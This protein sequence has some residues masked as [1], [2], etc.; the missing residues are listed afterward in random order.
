LVVVAQTTT[1]ASGNYTLFVAPGSYTIRASK[2]NNYSTDSKPATVTAGHTASVAAMTI[3]H[4]ASLT[5]VITD[6]DDA[7]VNGASVEIAGTAGTVTKT[8]DATGT[9]TA[10]GLA[11]GSYT[12]TATVTVSGV[13]RQTGSANVTLL[14]TDQKTLNIKMVTLATIAGTVHLASGSP[15][16]GGTVTISG[17]SS[18]TGF[19]RS[20]SIGSGGT[21]LVQDVPA[22]TN[23]TASAVTTGT[24]IEGGSANISSV[25]AEQ[26]KTG[27]DITT[28]K[29]S[30]AGTVTDA[31]SNANGAVVNLLLGGTQVD[32][33]TTKGNG[34]YSFT[35][36]GPGDYTVSATLSSGG[37][38][39][40]L[41]VHLDAGQDATSQDIAF[42]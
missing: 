36:L 21:Y 28:Q 9:Y 34:Q 29:A 22:G 4:F 5:G 31:G 17:T 27:V 20:G 7:V 12:V 39:K 26:Q 24:P 2:D 30:I 18:G 23:Y 6:K 19:T 35:G 42:P 10:A 33:F 40:T 32:T 25:A 13:L 8:T 41:A 14:T 37:S 1:D 3:T 38:S 15:A 11:A 16:S